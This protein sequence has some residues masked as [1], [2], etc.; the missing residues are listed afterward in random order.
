MFTKND[1]VKCILHNKNWKITEKNAQAYAPSNI[2]LAKYWGKRN[3]ELNLPANPSVSISLADK[4]A[5]AII[6]TIPDPQDKFI[7]NQKNV[8]GNKHSARLTQYLDL[9][10]GPK[11]QFY[12]L[13]LQVN[14]PFAAGLASSAC[15]FASIILA[16]NNLYAWQLKTHEL[17]ILARLGSGS[18][19]RSIQHGFVEWDK[20]IRDDGLDS[21]ATLIPI[22]WSEFCVGLCIF[23]TKEKAVSSREG[24]QHTEATSPFYADWVE[25]ANQSAGEIKSAI[26]QQDFLRLGEL[27]ETNA[28]TMHSTM[29]SANPPIRYHTQQTLDHIQQVKKLRQTGLKVFYTQDAGPNLK[30]LF[31]SSDMESIK[32]HFSN[33]EII[34]PFHAVSL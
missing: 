24:M 26:L 20:G 9:F 12:Q 34:Q 22:R 10:R 19:A 17:S 33:I 30:L 8:F 15:I 25:Y 7:I 31:L 21:F 28:A 23:E 27:A 1:T 6:N 2:A 32:Q 11:P 4:G 5:T 13:E 14:I 16:L 29:L 18:A 3:A